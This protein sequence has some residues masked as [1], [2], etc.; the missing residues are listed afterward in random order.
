[1]FGSQNDVC[2][3][4]YCWCVVKFNRIHVSHNFSF[5]LFKFSTCLQ[6]SYA[7]SDRRHRVCGFSFG[8]KCWFIRTRWG[9]RLPPS[10]FI[11]MRI[12][13]L[14]SSGVCETF[15]FFLS[16]RWA[17]FVCWYNLWEKKMIKLLAEGVGGSSLCSW[18]MGWFRWSIAS[19][20]QNGTLK[21]R[22]APDSWPLKSFS[23]HTMFPY[24]TIKHQSLSYDPRKNRKIKIGKKK[25]SRERSPNRRINEEEL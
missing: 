12:F 20:Y 7:L 3:C 21:V 25:N 22:R 2:C 1:M 6:T 13:L 18:W 19:L 14:I 10:I 11:Q 8:R 5:P 16:H 24:S 23:M 4:C 15:L 17:F 9:H